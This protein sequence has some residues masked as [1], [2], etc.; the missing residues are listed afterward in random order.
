MTTVAV[1]GS[2]VESRVNAALR[3]G[4]ENLERNQGPEGSWPCDYSGPMFLLPMYVALAHASGRL[5]SDP[6]RESMREYLLWAIH[7]DG[8]VGLHAEDRRGSMFVTATSYVALR[9]LGLEANDERALL[10]RR[11]MR[12]HGSALG[13]APWGKLVLA[14]LGLYGWEGLHPIQPELW[15]L[16]TSTP[17]HPSRL[18]CHCRQVYLPMAWLY[19]RRATIPL[20]PL[21]QQ[22]RSELYVQPYERIDFGRHKDTLAQTDAYRPSTKLLRATHRAL[23]LIES[24]V[25]KALRERALNEVYHHIDYEDRATNFIDIGPVNKVLNTFVRWFVAPQSADFERAM[26]MCDVYLWQGAQG[27]SMRGYN[28]SELWDTAFALQAISATSLAH[29]FPKLVER[30]YGFVRDNQI[31]EDPPELERHHRHRSRGGWPF[32][33]RPHGWPIS[34]CTAEGLKCALAWRGHFKN[35]V[36]NEL[37]GNAV[38]VLLS[39]QNEDGGFG[40]YENKRGPDWLE[41]LNP[42]HVFGEIMVDYSHVECTSACLQALRD[43]RGIA[44]S[45]QA[46]AI[47]TSLE[48]GAQHLRA[49]QLP[50]GSFEGAWAVCFTYGTWFGVSGLLAAGATPEDPAIRRACA[51][52]LAHQRADGAWGEHG[53]SC[54][55]RRYVEA[56]EPL[57][58]QTAWALSTLVRASDPDRRAQERAVEALLARQ[59]P[60]GSYAREPLVGVFNRTCLIDY[61]NY[62]HIFPLWALGEWYQARHSARPQG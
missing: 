60:D 6:R 33:N 7:A 27:T 57:M 2:D 1:S 13:A 53:D 40:T 36:P 37:M 50:D 61:D 12:D 62:R 39:F 24:T 23:A 8:G 29:E 51:F 14:V 21:I 10:M 5:Q 28:G 32:S 26:S 11:W 41:Q 44:T 43:A 49:R 22:L 31:L 59:L 16:P 20:D 47:E 38:D 55:E 45:A 4:L 17:V 9:L 42:S 18:W 19:G 56:P 46:K 48:L 58:A 54:R 25:P 30:A 52:L 34:D 3:R 15:L 35:A